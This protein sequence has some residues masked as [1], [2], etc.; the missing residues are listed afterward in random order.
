MKKTFNLKKFRKEHND[1]TQEKFAEIIGISQSDVSRY[2][3]DPNT[4]P[5][6]VALNIAHITASLL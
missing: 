4:L 5:F 3:N 2:E 1:L 6:Y